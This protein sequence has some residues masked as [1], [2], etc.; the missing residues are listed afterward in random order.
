MILSYAFYEVAVGGINYL[1]IQEMNFH[2][3][4]VSLS[5]YNPLCVTLR[6]V[7]KLKQRD[8]VHVWKACQE[9]TH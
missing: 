6:I 3:S 5:K 4:W 9:K 1:N 8:K 7:I 2:R